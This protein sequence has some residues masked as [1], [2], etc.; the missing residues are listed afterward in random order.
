MKGFSGFWN[1]PIKKKPID[2]TK[3]T[4]EQNRKLMQEYKDKS[5]RRTRP[6]KEGEFKAKG[7]PYDPEGALF[8]AIKSLDNKLKRSFK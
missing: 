1:S 8:Q 7:A 2:L 4:P 6:L 3:N 5:M